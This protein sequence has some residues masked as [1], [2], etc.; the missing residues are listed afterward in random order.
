MIKINLKE[1]NTIILLITKLIYKI[2][3]KKI[4]NFKIKQF[5][6]QF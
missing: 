2:I 5:R 3:L 6:K 4:F 1:I